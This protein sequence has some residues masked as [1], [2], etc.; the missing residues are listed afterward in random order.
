MG[1][2]EFNAGGNTAMDYHFIQGGLEILLV[3]SYCKNPD[4]LWPDGQRGLY[5]DYIKMYVGHHLISSIPNKA[6]TSFSMSQSV[7]TVR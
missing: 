5:T 7:D 3:A 2:S 4:K 1:A 6:L